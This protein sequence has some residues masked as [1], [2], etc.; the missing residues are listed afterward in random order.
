[1]PKLRKDPLRFAHCS[2]SYPIQLLRR[3]LPMPLRPATKMYFCFIVE[4]QYRRDSMPMVI[5]E[6]LL[7]WGHSVDLLELCWL[8]L[9][10]RRGAFR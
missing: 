6:R 7:Q 2:G 5:A 4:E 9:K 10:W 8:S 3:T 1:M